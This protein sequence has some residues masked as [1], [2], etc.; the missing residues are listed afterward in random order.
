MPYKSSQAL[1]Y[2]STHALTWSAT[3]LALKYNPLSNFNSRAH[4]ERDVI[5]VMALVNLIDFNSRAHVERDL[6]CSGDKP[7]IK[8]Q[9]Q[10]TRSRGA[11]PISVNIFKA[12]SY[13]NSR[14]HVER[15]WQ[16]KC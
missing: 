2:I 15:D 8:E 5:I 4:V 10:L 12:S 7:R 13:F 3:T 9:F 6:K 16:R 1:E 14:A 11:R